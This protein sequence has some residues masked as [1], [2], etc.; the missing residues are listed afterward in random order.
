MKTQAQICSFDIEKYAKE[1]T[2]GGFREGFLVHL[3]DTDGNEATGEIAPLP[4]RS[5]ETLDEAYANLQQLKN[6]FLDN[7]LTPFP[8][9][10][11]VMFGM[12]MA[13]YSLQNPKAKASPAMT[14]LYLEPPTLFGSK[15]P[16][17]LKLGHLSVD[18]AIAFFNKFK[19]SEKNIRI[20]LERKWELE[21]TLEFCEKIDTSSILYIEDPVMTFS[22]LEIFY[23][24]TNV[25]YAL[26]QFLAFAPP[27]VIKTLKGIHSIIVKPS[28]CGGLHE[29]R[30]LQELYA[31]V[32]ISISS[33]FET[34]VGIKHIKLI[35]S[36]LCPD[37]PV[38]CDTL[39]FL[40]A[41]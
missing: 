16:V 5:L 17:K 4:G 22:D 30:Q 40:K 3:K 31:P 1:Y 23:E 11:S 37:S 12:Q 14:K 38:G 29:C 39:K 26:D 20:D 32:P 19:R 9:Q 41:T 13:F 25:E 6:N 36:M 21:K 18:D 24:K 7:N 34:S 2:F 35:S 8:L 10:P 27:Q 28:L 15:G 33:L